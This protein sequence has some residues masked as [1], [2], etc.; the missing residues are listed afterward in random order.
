MFGKTYWLTHF[1]LGETPR[2]R[3]CTNKQIGTKDGLARSLKYQLY[4]SAKKELQKVK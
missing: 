3:N 2:C 4:H 1:D